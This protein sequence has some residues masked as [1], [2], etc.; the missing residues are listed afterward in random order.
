MKKMQPENARTAGIVIT[1]VSL[2]FLLIFVCF[3]LL[4]QTQ[5]HAV[6]TMP[7]VSEPAP[8]QETPSGT[9]SFL[10]VTP[11]NVRDVVATLAR[12]DYYH[13]TLQITRYWADEQATEQVD[14]WVGA[15]LTA[16]T[17][18]GGQEERHYLSDGATLYFW[19]GDGSDG[20]SRLSLAAATLDD[21]AGVPG[22]EMA[23]SNPRPLT[24]AEYIELSEDA[25]CLYIAFEPDADGYYDQLWV[26][27]ETG[28]LYRAS[29][30]RTEQGKAEVLVY[31]AEQ[32]ALSVFAAKDEALDDVF[33]LP[34]GTLPFA[35]TTA[36]TPES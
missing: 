27:V 16:L 36:E 19:R 33:R 22:Y 1:A 8:S 29:A 15:G 24:D 10:Q 31:Q 11:D 17:V 34:D 6:V 4:R 2:F 5:R 23:L 3:L 9:A 32:T 20:I 21:L 13:E 30:C 7:V 25:K 12:P 28:L 14:R 35:T 26:N 18:S